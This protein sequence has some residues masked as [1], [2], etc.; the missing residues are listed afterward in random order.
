MPEEGSNQSVPVHPVRPVAPL[1]ASKPNG[2]AAH[3]GHSSSEYSPGLQF[4]AE[5]ESQDFETGHFL[6]SCPVVG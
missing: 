4:V 5:V 3:P 6:Q 1:S 2:R